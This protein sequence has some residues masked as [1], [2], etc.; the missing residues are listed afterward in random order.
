MTRAVTLA[1]IAD[2]NTFVVDADNQRVGISSA[3]PTATLDVGGDGNFAGVVTA[4]SFVGDG[5]GLTGVAST[6]NIITGTAATFTGGV[7]ISGASN[8]N[9]SGVITATSFVGDATGLSGTPD[10]T[11][12]NVT[13]VA[14][15]FTGVLTYEDVTNVDSIGII[16]ARSGIRVGAGQS[17]GSDGAAVVYYGDGSNLDGVVSGVELQ[18]A[19]SSVG[20]SVTA[21]NFASGATLTSVSSGISTVT[22]AAGLNTTAS[23]PTANT[24]VTLNLGTAQHHELRLS[25]GFTTVTTSGGSFGESH[26]LVLIQPSSG[27]ATVGFSTFFQFPS[28]ATPSMSEGSSKVDLVSFVVKDIAGNTGTGATELLASAGLNYQ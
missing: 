22:I 25:A 10:I 1:E 16:T 3:N 20:T 14:A 19:G 15:T 27:I 5:T 28:G 11:V 23:S 9:V 6:D 24:V 26:S 21:I 7:N 8:I 13:G 12:R 18:Q 17:I 4:T 2:T